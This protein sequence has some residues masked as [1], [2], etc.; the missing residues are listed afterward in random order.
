VA[1]MLQIFASYLILRGTCEDVLRG[2]K[3]ELALAPPA[4][5]RVAAGTCDGP[6]KIRTAA[7]VSMMAHAAAGDGAPGTGHKSL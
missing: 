3:A 5:A 1:R 6:A 2:V 4:A 7:S